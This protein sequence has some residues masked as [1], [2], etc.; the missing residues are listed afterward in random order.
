MLS[1]VAIFSS[2][3]PVQ[4][5][6]SNKVF[7][8]CFCADYKSIKVQFVSEHHQKTILTVSFFSFHWVCLMMKWRGNMK[9]MNMRQNA[10]FVFFF[11]FHNCDEYSKK[12]TFC[13][14]VYFLFDL[15]LLFHFLNLFII[16]IILTFSV[17]LRSHVQ[18][19]S[20]TQIHSSSNRWPLWRYCR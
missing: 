12:C 10:C 15:F 18:L 8:L 19:V 3:H 9:R 11:F 1:K 5:R 17:L 16:I 13:V 7:L 6:K 2:E 4:Y 14:F 20:T